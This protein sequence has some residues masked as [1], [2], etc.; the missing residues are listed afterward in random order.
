VRI[1]APR[2]TPPAFACVAAAEMGRGIGQ[3]NRLPWPRLRAD[4]AHLKALT[5]QTHTPGAR[6]AVVMGRRTWD[7]IPARGQP[8]P[9]RL[10]V[11]ISR[12][13]LVLPTGAA[14]ATSLDD[15]LALATAAG[16]EQIFVIGGGQIFDRAVADPRCQYIYYTRVLA[17][18]EADAFFPE[19]EA[20]FERQEALPPHHEAGVA[21]QIERWARRPAG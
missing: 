10:N 1:L 16:V 12:G 14:A 17:R 8:L 9:D 20:A 7:S 21:Y 3:H 11:V 15:G 2:V 5:S 18:F 4:L 6:N 13:P 19:F